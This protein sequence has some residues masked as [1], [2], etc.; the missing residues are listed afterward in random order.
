MPPPGQPGSDDAAH[1]R[2]LG[3]R[4]RLAMSLNIFDKLQ[5]LGDA[6]PESPVADDGTGARKRHS[7]GLHKPLIW[8]DLEMSGLSPERDCILQIAV[9]ITDGS[10]DREIEGP[11]LV[12]H[13]PESVLESMGE[14]CQ[15]HHASSGLVKVRGAE[16]D[17]IKGE[18]LSGYKMDGCIE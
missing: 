9:I 18:I 3:G 7:G 16:V 11:E 2:P 15:E 10:L 14:W 12:I 1:W 5:E 6:M 4:G 17:V 13:Q 8:V